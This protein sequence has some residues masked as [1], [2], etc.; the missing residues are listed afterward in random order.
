M[1]VW[2]SVCS[3]AAS[4]AG[5]KRRRFILRCICLHIK[6]VSHGVAYE[7]NLDECNSIVAQSTLGGGSRAAYTD[8]CCPWVSLVV[9]DRL[10]Y[11]LDIE[12]LARHSVVRWEWNVAE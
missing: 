9:P 1:L 2:G 12:R 8:C 6:S 7:F 11:S 4:K 10:W 3:R 5:Q